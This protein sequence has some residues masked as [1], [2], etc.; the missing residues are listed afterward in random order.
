V[1]EFLGRQIAQ[2]VKTPRSIVIQDLADT[3][4]RITFRVCHWV[5]VKKIRVPGHR[6]SANATPGN[7][8]RSRHSAEP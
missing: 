8:F 4:E 7:G 3:V 1:H 2:S 6:V 5:T